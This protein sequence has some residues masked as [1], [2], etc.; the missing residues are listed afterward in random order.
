[1]FVR[2]S[3]INGMYEINSKGLTLRSLGLLESKID[4]YLVQNLVE[5]GQAFPFV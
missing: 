2:T 5:L 1:M 4:R 3:V